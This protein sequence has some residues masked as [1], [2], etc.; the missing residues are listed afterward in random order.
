VL[1]G[2]GLVAEDPGGLHH[3]VH[4]ELSPRQGG[5]ILHRA[6]PGLAAV[7]DNALSLDRHLGGQVPVH[8]IVLEEMRE[9]LGVGEVIDPDDLDVLGRQ[10]RPEEDS[11][12]P[13]EPVD[14]HSHCHVRSSL[15]M[16]Q[17]ELHE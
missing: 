2:G 3:D 13:P 8:G 4:S 10:R 15:S 6:H 7:H 9:R 1:R 17:S 5:R 11:T 14:S 12:D 16:G